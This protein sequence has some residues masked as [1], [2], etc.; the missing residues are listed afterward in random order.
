[1]PENQIITN[2][3]TKLNNF[4][5]LLGL[6]PYG[7]NGRIIQRLQP[8]SKKEIHAIMIICPPSNVCSDIKC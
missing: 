7:S 6:N 2:I 8:I 3:G 1:M 5:D 4:A